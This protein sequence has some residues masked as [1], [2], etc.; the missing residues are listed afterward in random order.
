MNSRAHLHDARMLT[1][2]P[3]FVLVLAGLSV[4]T[5][6]GSAVRDSL[7]TAFEIVAITLAITAL[8]MNVV[9]HISSNA[10]TRPARG[11]LGGVIYWTSFI[12]YVIAIF[13]NL[14]V[15]NYANLS[16][17]CCVSL[18]LMCGSFWASRSLITSIR[19][20]DISIKKGPNWPSRSS[21]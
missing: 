6:E 13:P 19:L 1:L 4:V 20:G 7:L 10:I 14:D 15:L 3:F 5:S 16:S 9:V 21:R 17:S 12:W 2:Y 8:V 11:L 18:S